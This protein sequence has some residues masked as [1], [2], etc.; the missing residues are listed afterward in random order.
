MNSSKSTTT[1][2]VGSLGVA[3]AVAAQPGEVIV[4][5]LL[6]WSLMIGSFTMYALQLRSEGFQSAVAA[7]RAS[8]WMVGEALISQTANLAVM[9][10]A[11][12][13][14]PLEYASNSMATLLLLAA[15]LL[16]QFELWVIRKSSNDDIH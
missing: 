14:T 5:L 12:K 4:T 10:E 6:G 8:M 3:L 2:V 1:L 9:V 13:N 7:L 11:G 16:I 15:L